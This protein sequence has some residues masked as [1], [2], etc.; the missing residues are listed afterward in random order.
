MSRIKNLTSYPTSHTDDREKFQFPP[1]NTFPISINVILN[2]LFFLFQKKKPG[3]L[4]FRRMP[5]FRRGTIKILAKP[6]TSCLAFIIHAS[7]IDWFDWDKG[8]NSSLHRPITINHRDWL[9]VIYL[10]INRAS[11]PCHE[12][13]PFNRRG[14][15]IMIRPCINPQVPG[16]S[17]N[18]PL[19]AERKK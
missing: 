10:S 17:M 6:F 13:E 8:V 14:Q 19:I 3:R 2:S 15:S 12:R 1:P 5:R 4:F 16:P 11:F 9:N 18:S 7:K